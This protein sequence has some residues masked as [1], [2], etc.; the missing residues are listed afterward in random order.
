M[1]DPLRI[2]RTG[3]IQTW[4]IDVP[5]A[6]NAI[7]GSDFIAAFD[8]AVDAANAATDVSVV[9]L[10]GAG[11]FFSAGG[12]VRDMRDRT[13]VFGLEPLDQRHG[14]VS[15]IQRIPRALQRLEV[16]VIAAVNGA[17]IGAG[18]DLAAMCDI[19]IASE[20]A[21]FA[22]SFVQL[23]LIPGDGGSWFLPR[24]IG[25]ARAAE[26][27]FT[28]DRVDA[29]TALSWGLVSEVVSDAELLPAAQRLA[30]RIAKNP[31]PA[32][33][34]AKRLLLESR[35]ASLDSTL[36]LAAAM[37]PLAHQD[38]EHHRRVANLIR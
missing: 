5:D 35:T 21:F 20:T 22:E 37:Q 3:R 16:P 29:A 9:I 23:G 36:A 14:Y 31:V 17:A 19:R 33:R 8:D 34:M 32:V 26:M 4:T 38:P 25:W 10:T 12:N 11:R 30:E 13:G 27:T 2:E 28:G 18:C 15:G 7:T 24:A 6:A 1:T